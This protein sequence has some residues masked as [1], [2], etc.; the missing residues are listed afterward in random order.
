MLWG[1]CACN[2]GNTLQTRR[3]RQKNRGSE[4]RQPGRCSWAHPP[5]P[6]IR[7]SLVLD[8][9]TESSWERLCAFLALPVPA[10]PYPRV[11]M[12]GA[13]VPQRPLPTEPALIEQRMRTYLDRLAE[14][15]FAPPTA[16]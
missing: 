1:A 13:S 16:P 10:F 2:A 5:T 15:A 8:T 7:P 12:R 9:D 4:R 14:E 11:H 3:K 6:L